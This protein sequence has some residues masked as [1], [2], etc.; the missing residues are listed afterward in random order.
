MKKRT[1]SL[2]L[3]TSMLATMLA[4][5]GG[6]QEAATTAAPAETTAAPAEAE[7]KAPE[8]AP[9]G[10]GGSLVYWSM[11][12]ATEPQGKAIQEAVDKFTADTGIAVDLQFKGRTGIREGLQPALDAGTN[13]D[14][15]DEDIDR[16]N[17]T[18]GQYLMDL[19]E[20][21]KASDYE[22]TANAGLMSACRDVAGGT[23][24]SIPYQPNVF[25][26]FYNKA[27]FEEAD[28]TAVPTTWEELDAACAKIKE[29]G[30]T[31]ITCDDAYITCMFGY[32]MSRLIGEPATEVVVKEGNW[33]DP[34]VTKTAEAYADFASKGYFSETI[35]S[36]VWPAGQNQE[37]AMGTAAMYLNGSWLPNEVKDMAGDDFQWGCFSYPAV[38]GG[39]DG[40]EA[41]NYGAQVLAINKDSKNAEAAFQLIEYITK[42]EF[43]QKLS[44]YSVGIPA[45]S[46]NTEWPALLADVKPVMDS[47]TTRYPW[48][49]GAEANAD[50]TPII[51]EN[52]LNL[53][54]GSIDAQGFVDALKAAGN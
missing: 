35:A 46:T 19:E 49:A 47:L 31:P 15:F 5:C 42:G 14:L 50:M 4:G 2:I 43:D 29:A 10:E 6:S 7:S 16:V 3:G 12:E 36:N 45:D 20:L 9:S 44:E 48:A 54:G 23:L 13:I 30:Y 37:L 11:W 33:D 25:A 28:V 51:K 17:T 53:C 41:A 32:H 22:A 24:K 27:I 1:L 21:A 18:W 39:V 38:E 8:A 40:V 34:A 52:F 26:F